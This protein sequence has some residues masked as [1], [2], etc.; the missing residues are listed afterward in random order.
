MNAISR[1]CRRRLAAGLLLVASLLLAGCASTGFG[2]YGG[3]YGQSPGGSAYGGLVGTVQGVDRGYSRIVLDVQDSGG[4]G[5]GN[6]VAVQYD[7]RTTLY[8][9]GREYPV[10]GLERGD[11]IRVDAQRSGNRLLARS[12]EV[13]RNIRE[14]GGG[15]YGSGYGNDYGQG[16]ALRGSVSYVD[17]R[18]QVLTLDGGYGSGRTQIRYDNRTVVEYQGRRYRPENLERGDVVSIQARRHGNQWMAEYIRVERDSR[19]Y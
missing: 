13:V 3:G 1:S 15:A 16:N 8:Y 7:Q 14:S 2:G 9:Q 12:I 19:R 18:T 5:R 17:P 4:Y 6:Q 10:E 11:V